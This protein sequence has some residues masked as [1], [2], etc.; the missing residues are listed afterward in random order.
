MLL[1]LHYTL[2]RGLNI[3]IWLTVV[4]WLNGLSYRI[5]EITIWRGTLD[6][7][8]RLGEKIVAQGNRGIYSILCLELTT[9]MND[10]KDR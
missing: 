1:I 9:D 8:R 7:N 5:T 4:I 10:M 2:M 3:Y 6:T